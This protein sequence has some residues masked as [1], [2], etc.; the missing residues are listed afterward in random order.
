MAA[1]HADH[2]PGKRTEGSFSQ[3]W[4]FAAFITALAVGAFITAGMIK[5]ATY[6]SPNDVTAEYRKE[7]PMVEGADSGS[8]SKTAH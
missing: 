3:G 2:R 1:H 5:K 6:R 8:Q 4:P 7:A